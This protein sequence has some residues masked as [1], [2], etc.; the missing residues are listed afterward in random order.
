[1]D[2]EAARRQMVDQQ[3]RTWEVLDDRV[4]V[5]LESVKREQFV[6]DGYRELAFADAEIPLGHGEVMLAPKVE[7][8]IL[9]A[10]DLQP[11]DLV[12]DVGTGSG[13]LAACFG[14]LAARVRS[15]DIYPDFIER[16]QANLLRA[17]SNN[18]VAERADA[19]QLAEENRYD[20]IAVSA[21]LP[22]YDERFQRALKIGGRL[23]VVVGQSPVM[24]AWQVTRVGEREWVRT[25]LFETVMR[26]LI[27]APRPSSFVF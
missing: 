1:M 15:L 4:L 14:R 2:V 6:P 12:L 9:Q 5:A 19:S 24:E 26:P 27:N 23:F 7:G 22:V 13:F 21:S 25:S 16:A 20:A 18:V 10:L 8:R 17:V 11:S 3:V